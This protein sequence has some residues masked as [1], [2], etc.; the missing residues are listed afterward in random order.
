MVAASFFIQSTP[1]RSLKLRYFDLTLKFNVDDS[2]FV[3]LSESILA[4]K[5]SKLIRCPSVKKFGI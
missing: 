5:I 2:T 3:S 1:K 4:L